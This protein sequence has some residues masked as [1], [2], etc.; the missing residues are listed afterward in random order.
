MAAVE[1]DPGYRDQT[2][3]PPWRD[4]RVLR[5]IGQVVFLLL[6]V[7]LLWYLWG[8]F[9][10][11]ARRTG[12]TTTFDFLNRPA[13]V[14]IRDSDF[15]PSQPVRDAIGVGLLNTI[16]V[17]IVGIALATILGILIGVGRLST[18][19]L[20]RKSAAVYVETLRNIPVL[21]WI[22]FI[23]TAVIL[24]LPPITNAAEWLGL[25]VFSNR[26]L[27][28]PWG[29][30]GAN[31]NAFL[32]A[33]AVAFV[34][35]VAVGVWRTKRFDATGEPHHR[36]L[37]GTGLILLIGAAAYVALGTPV[38]PTVPARD[39]RVVTGGIQLGP[40]YAALLIALT[41]YTASH[42]AEIV[43]GSIQAVPKGQTEAAQAIALTSF[44]RH[45]LRHPAPGLPHHGAP[46]GQPVPQ[47]DEEL[48][49]RAVHRLLRAHPRDPAGDRQRQ[50]G[51]P[52]HPRYDHGLLPLP[53]AHDLAR[54][55]HREPQPGTG[56]ALMTR[57]RGH[58]RRARRADR[59]PRRGSRVP[60]ATAGQW[61]RENLFN[62]KLNTVLT[63]VFGAL[64]ACRRAS[65]ATRFV[66]VTGQW[67]IVQVNLANY[68]GRA[69]PA[70]RAAPD[71]D[72]DLRLVRRRDRTGLRR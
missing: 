19:W 22:I 51:A 55:Q 69:L 65:V 6:V 68:H 20:V 12:L 40:E 39:G 10:T 4:V 35:A 13:G 17:S 64:I 9:T 26:G 53:V 63:I 47:P 32:A 27:V 8:N 71:L 37:W 43:R 61:V 16:R 56:V 59:P 41:I 42:I 49:A 52:A 2:R 7:L 48:L 54:R 31:V 60:P 24:K 67:E 15:R 46:A 1:Q 36:I 28:I 25:T 14:D 58:E 66:F 21:V 18:N 11:N 3:P 5:V 50:P 33:L 30:G 29:E 23:Y 34:V 72:R 38:E 62:S 57:C 45:A 70:R 44:Q